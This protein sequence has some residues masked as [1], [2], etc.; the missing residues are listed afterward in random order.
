MTGIIQFFIKEM[1]KGVIEL[2]CAG[3]VNILKYVPGVQE[4]DD[5]VRP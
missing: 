4:V 1:G 3:I 5:A 2:T